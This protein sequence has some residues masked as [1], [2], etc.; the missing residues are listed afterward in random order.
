MGLPSTA[1]CDSKQLKTVPSYFLSSYRLFIRQSIASRPLF[2]I[3]WIGQLPF[4]LRGSDD[5]ERPFFKVFVS[6]HTKG[7]DIEQAQETTN[8]NVSGLANEP[9]RV[10]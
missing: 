2:S 8:R 4:H 3:S 5:T 10:T 7:R 1:L 9:I 6:F